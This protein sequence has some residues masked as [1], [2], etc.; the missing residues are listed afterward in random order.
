MINVRGLKRALRKERTYRLL[1]TL[2]R[3]VHQHVGVSQLKRN[4]TIR[5]AKGERGERNPGREEPRVRNTHLSR[6]RQSLH[7][8]PS[9][10]SR[11]RK[12]LRL[13][14]VVPKE[15]LP[16][17]RRI[18]RHD[19][20]NSLLRC[21]SG[22]DFVDE[23]LKVGLAPAELQDVRSTLGGE[24][25]VAPPPRRVSTRR[26]GWQIRGRHHSTRLC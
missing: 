6:C 19:V 10:R 12:A 8:S 23:E 16:E 24:G 25:D 5:L 20:L 3:R 22:A 15:Q 7:Q 26:I 18:P 9:L 1:V 21:Q 14:V 4:P 17:L 2:E 13:L 11:P